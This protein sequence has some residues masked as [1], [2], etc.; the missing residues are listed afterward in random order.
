MKW[1][2]LHSRV[3]IGLA[4]VQILVGLYAY[5]IVVFSAD[6][7]IGELPPAAGLTIILIFSSLA[8][9]LIF[10]D[11]KSMPATLLASSFLLIASNYTVAPILAAQLVLADSLASVI[12]FLSAM[13]LDA[14]QASQ[15]WLFLFF[16]GR[17]ESAG[18][19]RLIIA[20]V[21]LT[22]AIGFLLS[23]V[24]TA[25]YLGSDSFLP[26][27]SKS[28]GML[29]WVLEYTLMGL[30]LPAILIKAYISRGIDLRKLKLFLVGLSLGLP[31][32]LSVLAMAI[33]EEFIGT[34]NDP[35]P[36]AIFIT[37]PSLLMLLI[38]IITAYSVTVQDSMGVRILLRNFYRFTFAKSLIYLLISI[39]ALGVFWYL[40]GMSDIPLGQL[41]SEPR[42]VGVL[43]CVAAFLIM[44]RNRHFLV[45]EIQDVFFRA[46]YQVDQEIIRL[47]K[48]LREVVTLAHLKSEFLFALDRIFCPIRTETYSHHPITGLLVAAN[49]PEDQVL[50]DKKQL[51][52]LQNIKLSNSVFKKVTTEPSI[53]RFANEREMLIPI[54]ILENQLLELIVV[55]RKKNGDD[56]SEQDLT[57]LHEFADVYKAA[58]GKLIAAG[59]TREQLFM[60]PFEAGRECANCSQI[61][62]PPLDVCSA[63]DSELEE[64]PLP[65]SIKT[66][67]VRE[68]IGEGGF[69]Q[70]YRAV[71]TA[72]DRTSAIKALPVTATMEEAD[73]LRKEAIL[74]AR[75]SHPNLA[76]VYGLEFWRD[77]PLLVVEYL[78]GGTLSDSKVFASKDL[79]PT[80]ESL[81]NVIEFI[82]AKGIWHLDIKPNNVGF[83][84]SGKL[85]LLDFGTANLVNVVSESTTN[86]GSLHS[87]DISMT[88]KTTQF[89]TL[90]GTPLYMSPEAL[91][92]KKPDQGFDIWSL[93]V[94]IYEL[95]F[96]VHPFERDTWQESYLA[97]TSGDVIKRSESNTQH[98]SIFNSLF[99]VDSTERPTTAIE[100]KSIF[101][102]VICVGD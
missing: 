67:E 69:G 88:R 36:A 19:T 77:V 16:F 91:N 46:P 73:Q 29:Y 40:Y 94:T 1:L 78:A 10:N 8:Y 55:G 38:P 98:Q 7:T 52:L 57:L 28:N 68:R 34:V 92:A 79:L 95:V 13:S 41:G 96:G 81:C 12:R 86:L 21:T 47:S 63:C 62:A 23:I 54:L 74:M 102:K 18:Y 9:F 20:G 60:K 42:T 17:N 44:Y 89:G 27:L 49:D 48:I 51:S 100:V 30:F 5:Q 14:F 87:L 85:K 43:A 39:P 70:V 26:F 83:D 58:L 4:S 101:E 97:I 3:L 71:D 25:Q 59:H 15:M 64:A 31:A 2:Q 33:S 11:R 99:S 53:H 75:I 35:I 84:A 61:Y 66:H 93:S 6:Q 72:L 37:L 90:T 80:I 56:Y 50:V 76:V 82:H 32:T 24:N 22:L 65:H 45:R